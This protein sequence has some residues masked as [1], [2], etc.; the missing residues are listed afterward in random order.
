MF[1]RKVDGGHK[2]CGV[3]SRGQSPCPRRCP[4]QWTFVS[5]VSLCTS[6]FSRIGGSNIRW[7]AFWSSCC[8][9]LKL[10]KKNS[11]FFLYVSK[12][13]YFEKKFNKAKHV[14]AGL[15]QKHVKVIIEER[16]PLNRVWIFQENSILNFVGSLFFNT[17][18]AENNQ[19]R[20]KPTFD[21]FYV[22]VVYFLFICQV[23]Y[24]CPNIPVPQCASRVMKTM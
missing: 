24:T 11:I 21:D 10:Q 4:V 22:R 12:C 16:W 13:R 20:K 15:P 8:S 3:T 17:I 14:L 23:W 1:G 19:A 18:S 5:L 6:S 9:N 2:I 7:R